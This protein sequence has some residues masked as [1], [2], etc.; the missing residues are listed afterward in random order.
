[1]KKIFLTFLLLLPFSVF[2]EEFTDY[3]PIPDSSF[4]VE[5]NIYYEF[6]DKVTT[7]I[8]FEDSKTTIVK[9]DNE[10][11]KPFKC[12]YRIKN[13]E[14]SDAVQHWNNEKDFLYSL[15]LNIYFNKDKE[16]KQLP[17]PNYSKIRSEGKYI[18]TYVKTMH[19]GAMDMIVERKYTDNGYI[20][21]LSIIDF[22]YKKLTKKV[23]F[24]ENKTLDIDLF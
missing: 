10:S 8:K 18:T 16:K 23:E 22:I 14:L 12:T 9:I 19:Y 5:K 7:Y 1:M 6:S 24:R 17:N 2:S 13:S 21:N 15:G 4:K 20:S 3:C 11:G